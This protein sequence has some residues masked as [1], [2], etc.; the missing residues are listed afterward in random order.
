MTTRD[1]YVYR[2]K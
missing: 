1:T 2:K